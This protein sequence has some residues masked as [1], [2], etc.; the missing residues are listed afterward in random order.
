[1]PYAST[2]GFEIVQEPYEQISPPVTGH[3]PST[4]WIAELERRRKQF[5]AK[6]N[7]P[8]SQIP[9]LRVLSLK[10]AQQQ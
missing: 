1:M 4:Q 7:N 3:G 8:P 5:T 6:E 10:G 9:V 2:V